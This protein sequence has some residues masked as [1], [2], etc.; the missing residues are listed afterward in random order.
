MTT[1]VEAAST[2]LAAAAGRMA[3][4]MAAIRDRIRGRAG[5]RADRDTTVDPPP[6]SKC[7]FGIE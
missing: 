6:R 2:G 7:R 1:L 3:I 5:A 4:A